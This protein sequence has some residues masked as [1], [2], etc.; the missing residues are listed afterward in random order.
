MIEEIL[1][2]DKGIIDVLKYYGKISDDVPDT[3]VIH[4]HILMV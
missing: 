4:L 1:A 3:K 2:T